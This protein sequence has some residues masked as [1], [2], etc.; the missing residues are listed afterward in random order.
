[1]GSLG[2]VWVLCYHQGT[3]L[4]A[5]SLPPSF[6]ASRLPL[7]Q[8]PPLSQPH[9]HQEAE[10]EGGKKACVSCHLL[11]RGCLYIPPDLSGY[12]PRAITIVKEGW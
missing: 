6:V 7:V 5:L 2:L 8:K 1:M 11:K 10:R 4:Q 9:S 12:S 3:R